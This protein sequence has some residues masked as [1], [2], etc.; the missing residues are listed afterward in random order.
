MNAKEKL[1][2][3]RQIKTHVIYFFDIFFTF[4]NLLFHKNHKSLYASYLG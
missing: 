1:K 2:D 4:T 3:I